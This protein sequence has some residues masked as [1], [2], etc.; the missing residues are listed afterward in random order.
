MELSICNMT[1]N[2]LRM[3]KN[4]FIKCLK[5]CFRTP[6]CHYYENGKMYHCLCNRCD[7]VHCK[8]CEVLHV[9]FET[10]TGRVCE[11]H[12][13]LAFVTMEKLIHIDECC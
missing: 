8:N 2:A 6:K 3:A 13:P 11:Q 1:V 9:T 4:R 7:Q 5:A 12:L 10:S